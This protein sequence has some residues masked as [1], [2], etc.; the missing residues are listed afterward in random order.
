MEDNRPTGAQQPGRLASLTVRGTLWSSVSFISGKLLVFLST[1]LLARLL[2]SDDFGVMSYAL[3]LMSFLDILSGF[4]IGQAVVYHDDEPHILDTAFWLGLAFSLVLLAITWLLAPL[5][6]QFFNDS[7]A[8]L[9]TRA[10]AFTFPI[11][12]AGS[13][14]SALLQ[15]RLSFGKK[16]IPEFSKAFCKGLVSI[17]MALMGF[18]FWSLVVGQVAGALAADLAFWWVLP[19]RPSLRFF[20]AAARKLLSYGGNLVAVDIFSIIYTN[21][22]YLLIGRFLGTSLL[23]VYTLAFRIPDL[24]INQVCN[25][26]SQ[27]VFP[28][29]VNLR[30]EVEALRDGFLASVRYIALVTT[31]LGLG[32]ALVAKPLVITFF[33]DKWIDCV[34][35]MRAL[36][37]YTLLL[38]W[39]YS[40]GIVYKAQGRPDVLS[41]V[42]LVRAVFTVPVLYWAVTSYGTLSAVGWAQVGLACG[43]MLLDMAV[44]CHMLAL[45]IGKI[46]RALSPALG[47][48]LV[49]SLAI[50]GLM[51]L[52]EGQASPLLSL[53]VYVGA[54]AG[55]YVG[56]LWLFKRSLLLEIGQTLRLA[57]AGGRS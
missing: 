36:S 48:G 28:L 13:I 38:S 32:L 14:H 3:V 19:W 41:R 30:G 43:A 40:A 10:L 24:V 29:F 22:D 11:D 37:L 31:P 57:I 8:V 27:V 25:V 20:K 33:T 53:A 6:G 12:A 49:M 15:K 55:V 54:G 26:I 4:G 9:A 51:T 46:A 56:V 7:R 45:P 34:P 21:V 17:L 39:G 16:F 35:V 18:G 47:S 2:T 52:F 42:E 23:G 5:A 44:A 50:G 1:I